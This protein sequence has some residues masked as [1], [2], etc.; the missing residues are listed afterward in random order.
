MIQT[1]REKGDH[2]IRFRLE[3]VILENGLEDSEMDKELWFG[4]MEPNILENGD[5]IRLMAGVS[6]SM[7]R[8][9]SMTESGVMIKLTV[10]VS[11]SMLMALS[12]KANGKMISSMVKVSRSGKM[13]LLMSVL[14]SMGRS[15]V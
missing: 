12:T 8:V 5:T 14:T 7:L 11:T 4:Q 9:T 2:L 3:L 13:V 1:I 6:S 15:K 10:S